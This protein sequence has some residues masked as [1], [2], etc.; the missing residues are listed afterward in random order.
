MATKHDTQAH[1]AV[2]QRGITLL[3]LCVVA[4]TAIVAATAL[5]SFGALID[6]HRL[7][8]CM[9]AAGSSPARCASRGARIA[10][11]R[12]DRLARR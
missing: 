7:E 6:S 3:E 5:P 9:P 8:R 4:V 2:R 1:G 12:H 10:A 11:R